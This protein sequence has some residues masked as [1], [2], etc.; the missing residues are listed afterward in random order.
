[1]LRRMTRRHEAIGPSRGV[2]SGSRDFRLGESPG[3]GHSSDANTVSD[4]YRPLC[5]GPLP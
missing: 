4:S 2:R 5:V 1:M 3:D